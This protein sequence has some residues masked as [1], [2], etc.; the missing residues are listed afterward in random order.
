MKYATWRL[1]FTNPEYGTGP[2]EKVSQ[3]GYYAEASWADGEPKNGATILGYL[4]E[5][6]DETELSAW[7]FKNITQEEAL[8]FCQGINP[9]AY[10]LE[11]G[12]IGIPSEELSI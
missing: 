5:N 1:N 10:L 4:T 11:D 8:V 6:Q 7:E 9:R 3:L 2:E 12:K